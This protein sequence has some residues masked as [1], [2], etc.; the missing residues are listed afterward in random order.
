[1][2]AVR[3]VKPTLASQ[4]AYIKVLLLFPPVEQLLILLYSPHLGNKSRALWPQTP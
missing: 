2:T 1:M 3:E 4:Q